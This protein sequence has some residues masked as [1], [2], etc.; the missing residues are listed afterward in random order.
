MPLA[1]VRRWSTPG[2]ARILVIA[3]EI[4]PLGCEFAGASDAG[5]RL[6][7]PAVAGS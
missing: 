2:A 5:T 3:A 6:T 4:S 7:G 1:D